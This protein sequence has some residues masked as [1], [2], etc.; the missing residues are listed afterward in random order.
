MDLKKY[1]THP[2]RVG[3]GKRGHAKLFLKEKGGGGAQNRK[4]IHKERIDTFWNK[5][6]KV[7]IIVY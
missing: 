2:R 3:E 5:T 7:K 6:F 1:N 4:A